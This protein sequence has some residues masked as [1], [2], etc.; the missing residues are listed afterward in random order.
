MLLHEGG[1]IMLLIMNAGVNVLKVI[2]H[3]QLAGLLL[4]GLRIHACE[5]EAADAAP[6]AELN[7]L[8]GVRNQRHAHRGLSKGLAVIILQILQLG[9]GNLHRVIIRVRQLELRPEGRPIQRRAPILRQY[10]IRS[11]NGQRHIIAQRAGPVKN[12]IAEH[13]ELSFV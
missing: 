5:D 2:I 7:E 10:I 1:D 12:Q 4:K 11:L 6:E 8:A 9:L 3:A 13:R